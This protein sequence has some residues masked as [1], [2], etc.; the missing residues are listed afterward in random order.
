MMEGPVYEVDKVYDTIQDRRK[1]AV[2]ANLGSD[3]VK[4]HDVGCHEVSSDTGSEE[5]N[6]ELNKHFYKAHLFMNLQLCTSTYN[7]NSDLPYAYPVE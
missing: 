2:A 6:G 1:K 3:K 5:V 7:I 4:Q